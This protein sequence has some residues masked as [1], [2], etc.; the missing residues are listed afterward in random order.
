MADETQNRVLERLRAIRS[1]IT[2]IN[3][4]LDRVA[5]QQRAQSRRSTFCF[6]KGA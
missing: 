2:A 1:D 3:T 4:K 6:R 5:T